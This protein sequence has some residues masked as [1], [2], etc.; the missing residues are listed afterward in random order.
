MSQAKLGQ[1]QPENLDGGALAF[2]VNSIVSR[3]QTVTLVKV[4]AVHSGGVAPVGLLD[5]QPLVAQLDGAG[6]PVA[7]GT[8]HNV[9][10]FRLQGGSNA[11]IIDPE[12]GDI[13]MCGFCSRDISAVKRSKTAAAPASRRRFDR[14]SAQSIRRP[15][16]RPARAVHPIQKRRH[17]SI[18]AGRHRTGSR[19]YPS[20]C[21]RHGQQHFRRLPSQ[22]PN[23][24]PIQRRRRH[25]SR[26]R[27]GGR[28][29]Q[30]A[31]PPARRCTARQRHQRQTAGSLKP[32]PPRGGFFYGASP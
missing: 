27:R 25:P 30:P 20:Q 17:Q 24:R 12:P 31:K 4:V 14:A 26:R 11:V 32:N 22:Y 9:P 8:I 1:M 29:Y 3:I 13:G 6:S 2:A 15:S 5:V 28:Q 10:Y 21:Q 16:Q 19:Q 23:R 18:F 7:H